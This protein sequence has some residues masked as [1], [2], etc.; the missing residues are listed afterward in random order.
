MLRTEMAK[1]TKYWKA[2]RATE[3]LA[4]FWKDTA[5]GGTSFDKSDAVALAMVMLDFYQMELRRI[6]E[7][8]GPDAA[9]AKK[10]LAYKPP[11]WR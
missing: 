7:R 6:A 1:I 8:G 5:P 2:S 3:V 9:A 4:K 10:A 11:V